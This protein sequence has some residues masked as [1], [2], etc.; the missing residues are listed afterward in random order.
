MRDAKNNHRD[1]RMEKKIGSKRQDNRT[2]LGTLYLD[3]FSVMGAL[4]L[5][6]WVST[7]GR[8]ARGSPTTKYINTLR[9]D[10]GL[11][12]VRDFESCMRD[13]RSSFMESVFIPL[14][15]RRRPKKRSNNFVK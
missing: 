11:E 15:S 14:S 4:Q 9:R 13:E 8:A 5:I 7:H 2:L 1:Y 6:T 12:N 3:M 10:T